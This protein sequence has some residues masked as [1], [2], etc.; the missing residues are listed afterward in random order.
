MTSVNYEIYFTGK[1]IGGELQGISKKMFQQ[2]LKY[3]EGRAV[4]LIIRKK[5]KYRSIQQ[6]KLMWV[7]Y[8]M[9][10]NELGNT[11]DEVHS[12][13]GERFLRTESVYEKTGLV[14]SYTRST[15]DLTTSEMMDYMMNIQKFAAEELGMVLPSPNEQ[16]QIEL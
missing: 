9:I 11:K 5:K 10:G 1:V 14:Y 2:E 8:T 3:F 12:L 16:T 6:N 4:E 13:L 7:Y 15:T